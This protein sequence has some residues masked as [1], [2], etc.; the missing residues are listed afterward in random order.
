MCLER[1]RKINLV[2]FYTVKIFQG[3]DCQTIAGPGPIEN[4]S[5]FWWPG[6]QHWV[7]ALKV[8]DLHTWPFVSLSLS[9]PMYTL[10]VWVVWRER[11]RK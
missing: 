11:W 5:D 9:E 2:D 4:K 7:L 8:C 1:K 6:K 3:R 10:Y